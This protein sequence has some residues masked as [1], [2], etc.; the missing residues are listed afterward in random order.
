MHLNLKSGFKKK[1]FKTYG[2]NGQKWLKNIP[3]I[4]DKCKNYWKISIGP[5][6]YKLSYNYITKVYLQNRKEAILKIGFPQEKELITEMEALLYFNKRC[7]VKMIDFN[8]ELGAILLE[9]INPGTSLRTIQ[10]NDD[11]KATEIAANLINN[12]NIAIPK[13]HSFP[14]IADWVKIFNNTNKLNIKSKL[15]INLVGKAKEIYQDLVKDS[16]DSLLLHGDLHHDNILYDRQKGWLAIDPK[17][18]I[19]NPIFDFAR[20]I[21]NFWGSKITS[22]LVQNRLEM[23]SS[24]V[25]YNKS[26][27][28]RWT[29][30]DYIMSNLWSIK[31][32]NKF[33]VDKIFIKTLQANLI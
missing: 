32:K 28:A 8:K 2:T 33:E 30:I 11:K 25:G 3:F 20:L 7:C 15:I 24:I 22:E 29:F 13:Q 17:G 10:V 6:N 1:I 26:L 27:L 5:S 14:K 16:Y 23:I 18:V 4:L 31:E 19:G 12:I 21:Q 9:K